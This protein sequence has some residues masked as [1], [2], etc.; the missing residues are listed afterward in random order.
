MHLTPRP[1]AC[2]PDHVLARRIDC[3]VSS[4]PWRVVALPVPLSPGLQHD[5]SCSWLHRL[6]GPEQAAQPIP[7]HLLH[8]DQKR[9]F[10][11]LG[12]NEWVLFQHVTLGTPADHAR[13]K[14]NRKFSVDAMAKGQAVAKPPNSNSEILV[15]SSRASVKVQPT[16]K[17][18]L[19]SCTSGLV[20]NLVACPMCHSQRFWETP[21]NHP[22]SESESGR[23]LSG[24]GF[25]GRA[26]LQALPLRHFVACPA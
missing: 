12:R 14:R 9:S 22:A 20:F 26:H 3:L 10:L 16:Q 13:S 21:M 6:R 19:T 7:C 11:S 23:Q 2:L 1:A 8:R 24:G 15:A 4:Y 25:E 5:D 17:P 18:P